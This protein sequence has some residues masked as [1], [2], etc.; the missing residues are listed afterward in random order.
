M[1]IVVSNK[2]FNTEMSLWEITE[3]VEE[4]S[5]LLASNFDQEK[6]SSI[7]FEEKKQQYLAAQLLLLKTCGTCLIEYD[8]NGKPFLINRSEHISLSHSKNLVGLVFDKTQSTGIDV[9]YKTSKILK[10]MDRFVNKDEL[11]FINKDYSNL[12]DYLHYIWC[13]KEAIFKVYGTQLAFKDQIFIQSFN[14]AKDKNVFAIVKKDNQMIQHK[15][16]IDQ[17]EN[18]YFAYVL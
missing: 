15:L 18:A 14:P 5:F 2:H 17:L 12:L 4:L 3:S 16:S 13:C 6:V 11:E 1:P 9:Q 8:Q 7:K 10:I